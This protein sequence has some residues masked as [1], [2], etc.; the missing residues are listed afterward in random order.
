MR[1]DHWVSQSWAS[2]DRILR[3]PEKRISPSD[4]SEDLLD[5][6]ARK[7]FSPPQKF[8]SPRSL[9][10]SSP[11]HTI[12]S[13]CA[14]YIS[15]EITSQRAI[16]LLETVL[17]EHEKELHQFDRTFEK[18]IDI[19]DQVFGEPKES[20]NCGNENDPQ[21]NDDDDDDDGDDVVLD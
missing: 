14:T 21:S 18:C 3:T 13:P 9:S 8:Q 5:L 15:R 16:A 6:T 10:F 17:K 12:V 20:K 19:L 1:S 7:S 2:P 11:E 4:C